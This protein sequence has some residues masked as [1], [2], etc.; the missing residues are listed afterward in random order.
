MKEYRWET[1]MG[2]YD[3]AILVLIV[4]DSLWKSVTSIHPLEHRD[5]QEV[6]ELR[7]WSWSQWPHHYIALSRKGQHGGVNARTIAHEALHVTTNI[8]DE[9]GI[10][11]S[12]ENDEAMA[13][14]Q[15]WIIGWVDDCLTT[16]GMRIKPFKQ[17]ANEPARKMRIRNL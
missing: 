12:K 10:I 14:L 13:Y 1:R 4:T 2:T 7:G 5:E 17:F 11:I 6:N 16:N 3:S 9:L 8:L 15:D